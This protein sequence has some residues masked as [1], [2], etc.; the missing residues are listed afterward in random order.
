MRK[1]IKK[2]EFPFSESNDEKCAICLNPFELNST[3]L[4]CSHTF[5]MGCIANWWVTN[6]T[7]PYCRQSF[8]FIYD[9]HGRKLARE[10]LPGE[11]LV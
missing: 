9:S 4:P 8:T 2:T 6:S 1:I 7:C 3:L 11:V 10:D 5:C